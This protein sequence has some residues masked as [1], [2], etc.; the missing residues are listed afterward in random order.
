MDLQQV[1]QVIALVEHGSFSAAARVCHI[2][3]PA[4]TKS[5][6]RLEAEL[7]APLFDR[8]PRGVTLTVFGEAAARRFRI[9]KAEAVSI[10]AEDQCSSR[11]HI[12]TA[13]Y[14]RGKYL[15]YATRTIGCHT[16]ACAS[17]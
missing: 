13:C 16:T 4:L 1:N 12:G 7:G 6:K 10:I 2:S 3:Q 5:I 15:D 17:P 9:M 14:W 11:R 8:L